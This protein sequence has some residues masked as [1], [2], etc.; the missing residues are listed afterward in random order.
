MIKINERFIFFLVVFSKRNKKNVSLF[1]S[2]YRNTRESL[3]KLEKP[4]ETLAY[5][6]VFPQHFSFYSSIETQ[7]SDFIQGPRRGRGWGCFSPP[8]P[9]P[10]LFYSRK[11]KIIRTKVNKQVKKEIKVWFVNANG[12]GTDLE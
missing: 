8:P 7:T 4:V 9:P 6:L 12:S 3:G 1:L 2:S 5:R 11:K 10:P